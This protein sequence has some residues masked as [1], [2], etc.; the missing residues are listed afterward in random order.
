VRAMKDFEYIPTDDGE[1]IAV[2]N[3]KSFY[4]LAYKEAMAM[5]KT[6]LLHEMELIRTERNKCAKRGD[7]EGEAIFTAELYGLMD[8]YL[9]SDYLRGSL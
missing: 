6:E 2:V 7:R 4:E 5:T 8:C 1:G 9:H 3:M